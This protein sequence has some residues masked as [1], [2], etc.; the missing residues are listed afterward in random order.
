MKES[1]IDTYDLDNDEG[2]EYKPNTYT[3]QDAEMELDSVLDEIKGTETYDRTMDVVG[4]KWDVTSRRIIAQNPRVLSAI[5]EHMTNG[6]Y[7]QVVAEIDRERTLGRL[8]GLSDIEA[9]RQVGDRLNAEGKF[10][11]DAQSAAPKESPAPKTAKRAPSP[12]EAKRKRA[13][14]PT[15]SGSST[16]SPNPSFNPLNLSDEEFEK[17]FN[18]RFM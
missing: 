6:V 11:K 3:V 14:S 15:R 17:Q 16:A 4:N 2:G 5:N 12:Q 10:N 8:S 13:A 18:E 7:D 1:G 9:Y